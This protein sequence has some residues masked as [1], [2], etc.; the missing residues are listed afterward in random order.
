MKIT[1]NQFLSYVNSWLSSTA[2][3]KDDLSINEMS[4]CLQ[5]AKLML[6]DGQDGIVAEIK[7]KK[8]YASSK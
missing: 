5:N 6:S 4:A 2:I 7:R 1:A 8:Y 3:E